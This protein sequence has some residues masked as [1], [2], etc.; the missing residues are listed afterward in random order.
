MRFNY[1]LL[2]GKTHPMKK[3][4][5]VFLSVAFLSMFISCDHINDNHNISFNYKETD[6][7][8]SMKAHF[9]KGSNRNVE[10]YM[11]TRIGKKNNMSFVNSTIDGKITLNDQTTF[12]IKKYPGTL[13][14]KLDK[15]ENSNESYSEIK[16]MCQ[17]LKQVVIN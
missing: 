14:I 1:Y 8:Y 3:I 9:N 6:H 10:N 5:L 7:T 16:A 15:N 12:Y 2:T 13:E 4:S 11:D 17:G